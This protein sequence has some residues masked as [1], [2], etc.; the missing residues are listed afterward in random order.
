MPLHADLMRYRL[1]EIGNDEEARRLREQAIERI[2]DRGIVAPSRWAG[3]ISPG[4]SGLRADSTET[5]L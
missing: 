4:F 1:G 3:M 2:E 5:G